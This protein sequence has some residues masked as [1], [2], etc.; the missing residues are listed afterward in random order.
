MGGGRRARSP[1][2]GVVL[3]RE[4]FSEQV[5]QRLYRQFHCENRLRDEVAAPAQD[6]LGAAFKV[7]VS[8]NIDDRRMLIARQQP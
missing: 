8:G 4:P 2:R 5:S 6:A 7:G 3:R 1:F